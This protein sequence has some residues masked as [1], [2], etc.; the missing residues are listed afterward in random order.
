MPLKLA[1]AVGATGAGRYPGWASQRTFG[2]D[3]AT[4]R[5]IAA[6]LKTHRGRQTPA[7]R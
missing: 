3:A 6:A 2:R 7:F 1:E 5:G 4:C